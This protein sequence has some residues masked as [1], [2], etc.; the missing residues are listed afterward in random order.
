MPDGNYIFLNAFKE[1]APHIYNGTNGTKNQGTK[2]QWISRSAN[3]QRA[4]GTAWRSRI[5]TMNSKF[6]S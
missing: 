3:S 4:N 5:R 1:T 6:I 2:K